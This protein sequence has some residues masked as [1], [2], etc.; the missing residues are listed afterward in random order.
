[1]FSKLFKKTSPSGDLIS[2]QYLELLTKKHTD[3]P[4]WARSGAVHFVQ[5]AKQLIDYVEPDNVLDYGCGKGALRDALIGMYDKIVVIGYDPAI[6]EFANVPAEPFDLVICTDVL[7]HIEP[8]MLDNVLAHIVSLTNEFAYMVIFTGDCGHKLPDGSPCH[9]IQ[10]PQG[11]WEGKLIEAFGPDFGFT[12]EDL[13]N[14]GLPQ[15]FAAYAERRQPNEKPGTDGP[16]EQQGADPSPATPPTDDE[17]NAKLQAQTAKATGK[18]LFFSGNV[19]GK[20]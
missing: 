19:K 18:G 12:F 1:M 8:E 14:K 2:P 10:Q 9:L 15:R 17:I 5:T 4:E 11:W 3:D 16:I 20:K 13:A 6:A 7:E